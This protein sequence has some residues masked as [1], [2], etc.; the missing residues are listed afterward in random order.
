MSIASERDP[1]LAHQ[2]HHYHLRAL[3]AADVLARIE[4]DEGEAPEPLRPL[5][6]ALRRDLFEPGLTVAKL[7][8]RGGIRHHLLSRF[9]EAIGSP[10]KQYLADRRLEVAA[11][12]L[13]GSDLAAWR[14]GELVGYTSQPVFSRAFLRWAS[15]R[16]AAFRESRPRNLLPI[17][18]A[19][20]PS[21]RPLRVK[22]PKGHVTVTDVAA[23][24]VRRLQ[25]DRMTAPENLRSLFDYLARRLFDPKLNVALLKRE[26]RV[27]DNGRLVLFH[28]A[29]GIPPH[30]YIQER[31][32]EAAAKLL[33]RSSLPVGE[34]AQLLGYSGRPVLNRAFRRYFDQ[35]S[36]A[37][38]KSHSTPAKPS[39]A[40]MELPTVRVTF[41]E[42][43]AQVIE[44]I[45]QDRQ[46]TPASLRPA[47]AFVAENLFDPKLTVAR[48][49]REHAEGHRSLLVLFHSAL[50]TAPRRYIE[51]RRLDAGALMLA[52]SSL[53][54]AEIAQ[55]VGC[56]TTF[57]R[58][59][60]RRF[61]LPPSKYRKRHVSLTPGNP[62][63][64]TSLDGTCL[65]SGRR[66]GPRTP[67]VAPHATRSSLPGPPAIFSTAS[68]G[69][70]SAMGDRVEVP[71][72]TEGRRAAD[73]FSPSLE[74]AA[75]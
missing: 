60:R 55:L 33:A 30:Q 8:R 7:K 12:L 11:R 59:F 4:R 65:P 2:P 1:H 42:A 36:T 20:E 25:R 51:H 40:S 18:T 48:L 47:L 22:L 44:R 54:I 46:N 34:I 14:I 70:P 28:S 56:P 69:G 31:R 16:P 19:G 62:A 43:T 6:E 57:R 3:A 9:T 75:S 41:E 66:T 49:Q 50:D 10:P 39:F 64:N 15:Q 72:V 45:Q 29:L 53:P 73:V 21:R 71:D 26:C 61:G 13:T 74:E 58:A 32:L 63:M 52:R 68:F 27:R 23:Q 17:A 67:A 38:R 24:A 35:R 37:Y 5:L